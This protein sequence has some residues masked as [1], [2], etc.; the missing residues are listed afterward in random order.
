MSL[1]VSELPSTVERQLRSMSLDA[2]EFKSPLTTPE[3]PG[4][5]VTSSQGRIQ[6]VG[7]EC[8]GVWTPPPSEMFVRLAKT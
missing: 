3:N 5:S 7:D 6:G 1:R 4:K 2:P 8:L